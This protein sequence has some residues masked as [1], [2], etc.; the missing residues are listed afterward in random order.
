MVFMSNHFLFL[1]F[2]SELMDKKYNS[3]PTQDK[4]YNSFMK[5]FSKKAFFLELLI[6]KVYIFK[7]FYSYF[8][9]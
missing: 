4:K 6:F 1:L 5:I 7:D 2:Y 3:L 9:F 8:Y